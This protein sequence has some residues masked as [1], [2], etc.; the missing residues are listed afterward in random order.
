MTVVASVVICEASRTV[1]SASCAHRG[2]VHSDQTLPVTGCVTLMAA[3]VMPL[4]VRV[5]REGTVAVPRAV[6]IVPYCSHSAAASARLRWKRKAT[7]TIKAE[8]RNPHG[9]PSRGHVRWAEDQGTLPAGAACLRGQRLELNLVLP[10]S[11]VLGRRQVVALSRKDAS[12]P[13][14]H[15]ILGGQT[16]DSATTGIARQ[17]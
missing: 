6:A 12:F 13:K 7:F 10:L 11:V 15:K 1:F 17:L 3:E 2:P 14:L 8:K 9:L 16:H 5:W 4:A